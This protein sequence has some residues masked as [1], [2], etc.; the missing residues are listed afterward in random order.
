M[1]RTSSG[2]LFYL[3]KPKSLVS[4]VKCVFCYSNHQLYY[5][6]KK[7]SIE[8]RFWNKKS[9]RAK[10]TKS[11]QGYLDFNI[12][13]DNIETAILSCYRKYIN[14]MGQEPDVD[15]LR[16]LVRQKR[17]YA[18]IK[19]TPELFEFIDQFIKHAE[20]GK[21]LNLQT[22][23][24]IKETTIRTYRQ[25]LSLLREFSEAKKWKLKFNDMNPEFHKEFVHFLSREYISP[26][27]HKSFKP[28][29]VGK[30]I[31]NLKTFLS[32]A[33][34][35]KITTNQDFRMKGFKVLKEEVDSIYLNKEEIEVLENISLPA[36]SFNEK[37]RDLFVIGC[38]T[39]LRISDLK[40]LSED[41]IKH[42]NNESYIEIEML[43]TAKPVTI[44]LTEKLE[45]L[46]FKYKTPT[47]HFFPGIH[48]Q[49]VND[50]IKDVA[51]EA[52]L[53]K[54]E[55]IIN[56]TEKGLRI[57]KLIPKCKLITNHT[58]RRSFATNKVLEGYPYSAIMLITGHK[59]EKAFLRYVKI[60]GYDAVKIFNQ[61]TDKIKV[62]I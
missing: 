8:T 1:S 3:K 10:E 34:E 59:T 48:D 39:G 57:S 9:Q 35:R 52:D 16:T 21:H 31:T 45:S 6:E 14:D 53:F 56:V 2:V 42:T 30:H 46:L 40:R 54:K 33:F 49:R 18:K 47:G 13:L 22:G 5:Y 62:A 17:G 38:H 24:P 19:E 15:E 58:A 4:P 12:T 50:A 23:K 25:T 41:H 43:K 51:A 36:N 11:F 55:V 29:S 32:N 44:P 37:V 7:L 28:N 61:H 27:S 20:A 60:S 26:E